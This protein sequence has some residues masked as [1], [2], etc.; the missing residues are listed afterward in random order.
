MQTL[1][2]KGGKPMTNPMAVRTLAAIFLAAAA[3][4]LLRADSVVEQRRAAAP[5]GLVEIEN[6]SGSIR[7]IGW[8]QA[9]VMVKGTLGHGASGLNLSGAA[10]R[11]RVEVEAEG[12]PHGVRSDIEVRVPVGSRVQIDAFQAEITVSGVKGGVRAETVNGSISVT[13]ATKDV[14]VQSVNGAVEVVGSGGRVHAEAVNGRVSVKDANGEVDASTVNGLLSVTGGTFDRVRLETVSGELR[15]E[16]GLGKTATLDAETVSGGVDIAL[17][18]GIAADFS[19]TTFSGGVDNELG[20][21]AQKTS[22]WTPEKEL[23]FSTGAG[24]AKVNVQ[25]LSGGIR[26]R[27][28]P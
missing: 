4:A 21:P 20:P 12:N 27:K 18:A 9:E 1:E 3:P 10:R 8:D 23:S 19:I 6:A 7:V 14:D 2:N 24:G 11:T 25:T 17:P 28:K 5:D 16:G 13:G 26:L 22:K 15:F